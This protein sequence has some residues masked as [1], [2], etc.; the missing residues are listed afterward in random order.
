MSSSAP[1]IKEEVPNL[2]DYE[3]SPEYS[4]GQ[5]PQSIQKSKHLR[6]V[7]G[8]S[9]TQMHFTPTKPLNIHR[10]PSVKR[11][12]P[13]EM[14]T[15]RPLSMAEINQQRLTAQTQGLPGSKA[16]QSQNSLNTFVTV[17]SYETAT[18]SQ[19]EL[20]QTP[21]RNHMR[22]LSNINAELGSGP[23]TPLVGRHSG[24]ELANEINDFHLTAPISQSNGLYNDDPTPVI[25][26]GETFEQDPRSQSSSSHHYQ[27]F[28]PQIHYNQAQDQY[29]NQNNVLKRDSTAH[30]FIRG[31]ISSQAN[32]QAPRPYSYA[33][34][35]GLDDLGFTTSLAP[36]RDNLNQPEHRQSSVYSAIPPVLDEFLGQDDNSIADD[37]NQVMNE[38]K[39]K[40]ERRRI[41]SEMDVSLHSD[42]DNET[43][44]TDESKHLHNI[45]GSPTSQVSEDY[46]YRSFSTSTNSTSDRIS[47]MKDSFKVTAVRGKTTIAKSNGETVETNYKQQ[48]R[49]KKEADLKNRSGSHAVSEEVPLQQSKIAEL[50][51]KSI[52]PGDE[53]LYALFL[54]AIHPFDA[55]SLELQ[56]DSS[57]CLS[58]EKNDVV[59]VHTVDASGWG[60]VTLIKTLQRGWVPVNFFTELIKNDPRLPMNKSRLPL[61]HLLISAAKFLINPIETDND[62]Y[63]EIID[64]NLGGNDRISLGL[65][66][67]IRDG[68]KYI[69][70]KTD[71][72]SRSTEIVRQRPI[73]RKIRKALLADWYS[74]MIKAD[75]YK[76]S[77]KIQHLETLQLMVLQ[78]VKK[79][80][81]FLEI[82]GIE[83]EELVKEH[84]LIV[85]VADEPDV[86]ASV[87]PKSSKG[88]II[89]SATQYTA[90]LP[91]L[92]AAPFAKERLNEVYN[93][94]FSYIGLL[95]GR[96]DMIEHNP[97]GCQLLENVTHQM[98]ILLRELLFI[99]KSCSAILHDQKRRVPEM[100]GED[101]LDTLLSLVSELVSSVKS[102][103][104]KTINEDY[105]IGTK[106]VKIDDNE[107]YYYSSEGDELI[108]VISRMT[109]AVSSSVDNCQKALSVIGNFRLSSDKEFTDFDVIRITPE[110]FIK[111]CSLGL[112]KNFKEQKIDLKAIKRTDVKRQSRYSMIRGGLNNENCLTSSGSNL[113]QE[114]LPD[115]KSFVRSSVFEPY[116]NENGF[117]AGSSSHVIQHSAKE[118][119]VRD[120]DGNLLGAS[121]KGLIF[122]LTD[123]TH[124]KGFDEFF[125]N[126][127]FLTFKLFTNGT[128]V[129]EELISRFNADNK[130]PET[131]DDNEQVGGQFSSVESQM[132]HRRKMIV[133]VFQLWLQSYWDY[134]HDYNLLPTL[135]N[136]FNEVVSE[137]LPIEAKQLIELASQITC[138]TPTKINESKLETGGINLSHA[139]GDSIFDND[140]MQLVNS[141]LGSSRKSSI[142]TPSSSM[143]SINSA[144]NL[145]LDDDEY[146]FE[147]YNLAKI[148]T[149]NSRNSISLPLPGLHTHNTSLLTKGQ[150]VDLER[151]VNVY[152]RA[153]GTQVWPHTGEE[154]HKIELRKLIKNWFSNSNVNLDQRIHCN[155]DYNIAELNSYEVAKQITLIESSIF[156]GIKPKELINISK[157]QKKSFPDAPNVSYSLA[158]TNMLS[159]YIL[160]SILKTG[161]SM[162]R[163][164]LRLQNWLNV[165]LS[166]YY[167]KNFNSLACIVTSL[168]SATLS[169]IS[170][171]WNQLPEKYHHLFNDLQKIINYDHN[172]KGYRMKIGKVLELEAAGEY[173]KSPVP[174]VPYINLYI[175]DLTFIDEGNKDFRNSNSFLRARIINYDKFFKIS[176]IM[177]N[178][179]F[180]QVSYDTASQIQRRPVSPSKRSSM[181]SFASFSSSNSSTDIIAA[182]PVVQEYILLEL[183]RVHQLGLGKDGQER[184]WELAGLLLK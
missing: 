15:Q 7:S 170:D 120:G 52:Q 28:N 36:P 80:I 34:T 104:T 178:I 85:A 177:S 82:W 3:I 116:L 172:Y 32:S 41:A 89:K 134:E 81:G 175:Q 67:D 56:S 119:I 86:S 4:L 93:I 143:K 69:L 105:F 102:F 112:I 79:S 61:N 126:S 146:I 144:L 117:D 110:M 63:N 149:H 138:I 150:M 163:R 136:F 140:R 160:D 44:Y 58:F 90:D 108:G 118:E 162:K 100:N 137:Y 94:L 16:F 14:D 132:K 164:V 2:D 42:F 5:S 180:L 75:S 22:N 174:I 37:P 29:Q 182:I 111:R 21:Q 1:D 57:I 23:S 20:V 98:I 47:P 77:K 70:E 114:F 33:A 183:F 48:S 122:L 101:N 27:A 171:L 40:Q 159:E 148:N 97:T 35:P 45:N 78:V 166:C 92:S 109:R 181:F 131:D 125:A 6:D 91:K 154:Y 113:L 49:R 26:Q 169:R 135:I 51:D 66:N 165:A 103:V 38:F 54:I 19:S 142:I 50:K 9:P 168:Q 128:D 152:R 83:S 65:I 176:K 46:Q 156:R 173:A 153:L 127:F 121:L 151:L 184:F 99:S 88:A 8:V 76:K 25:R 179:E 124:T 18:E 130:R 74:L 17:N 30:P 147:E 55:S 11:K 39:N 84:E 12:I 10:E 13:E 95:L 107:V 68:V 115:S 155:E 59:F 167:L 158:F 64:G 60:E 72:L 161:V 96:L 141:K 31:S 62:E 71:C 145:D 73:I 129:I 123:E 133:K 139:R 53:E 106:T 43:S 24:E 87:T 157:F